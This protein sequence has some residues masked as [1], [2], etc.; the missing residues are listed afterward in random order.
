M[1]R[2]WAGAHIAKGNLQ[3]A[4]GPPREMHS[5]NYLE[6]LALKSFMAHREATSVLLRLDN[7]T[8]IAF[9]NKMGGGGVHILNDCQIWRW[10]FGSWCLWKGLFIHA[11]HLPGVENTRADW[12]SRHVKESGEPSS[13]RTTEQ[14]P[15]PFLSGSLC[16]QD[17][18]T[19]PSV[20]Q[21]EARSGGMVSGCLYNQMENSIPI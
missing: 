7:I 19:T 4:H 6:L 14:N 16:L 10:I 15:W 12:E 9:I 5:I 3:E 13:I 2:K 1:P 18:C 17:K 20:L 8:A 11:E 21:L